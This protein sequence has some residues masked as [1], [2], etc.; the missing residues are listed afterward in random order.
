MRRTTACGNVTNKI[1]SAL[2]M[3]T[4][5]MAA[6]VAGQASAAPRKAASPARV[7]AASRSSIPAN[8]AIPFTLNQDLS[9]KINKQGDRF[10]VTAAEDVIVNGRV[11]IPR[12]TPGVGEISLLVEK[13]AFGKSG[14]L[15]TRL[16]YM[17]LGNRQI[18]LTGQKND[19]GKSGTTGT[20][21]TA[22]AAGV[23]S[24]FVTGKSALLPQGT[25][26]IAYTKQEERF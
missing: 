14:K 23:F 5:A 13:G 4:L 15:E 10:N 24:A 26:M 6:S 22:V 17:T 19:A 3:T 12:G 16:L 18:E 2:C 1:A 8:T 25:T 20:V 21:V 11:A 7:V 9:S